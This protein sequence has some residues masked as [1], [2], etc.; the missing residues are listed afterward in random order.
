MCEG[1]AWKADGS[2]ETLKKK[3]LNQIKM[4]KVLK[5]LGK[6]SRQRQIKKRNASSCSTYD[7]S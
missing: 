6:A 4:A 2:D 1:E 5:F 3:K 7:T